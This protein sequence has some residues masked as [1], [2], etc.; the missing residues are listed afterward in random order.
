MMVNDW[1]NTIVEHAE[2]MA[3]AATRVTLELTRRPIVCIVASAPRRENLT[4]RHAPAKRLPF[5]VGP[6]NVCC[7]SNETAAR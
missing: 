1:A 4:L 3:T 7:A 2:T 5:Q 6:S